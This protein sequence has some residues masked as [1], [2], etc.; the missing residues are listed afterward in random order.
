MK[1]LQVGAE[2][3][4]LVKTGGLADVLGALPQALVAAGADVRLLLP[5]FPAILAGLKKPTLVYEVGAAFGAA[6]VRLLRGTIAASG[7]SAYVVDAPYFYQRAGNPYLGADGM[8][9]PD[10]AQRFALLGWMAAQVAA[11]GLDPSWAPDV[12]HAHDWHA[13][14]AC[15]YVAANPGA[16]VATVYTVHNLAYQGLFD[17][18][19]F[20][21]LGLPV[22]FMEPTRLEYHGKFSFMKAGLTN[23]QRVTTVSPSYAAEIASSEFGCGLDGVVRSRG[24]DVSGILNGVDDAVWNPG[25]DKDIVSPYSATALEGKAVSKA[26][27]QK[28]L[29][30]RVDPKVPLFTVVSRLTEQ[31]GLDLVL[32]AIPEMLAAGA[33]LAVQGSGDAAL[34]KAFTDAMAAHPGVVAVRLGYD[35]PFAHQMIAGADA[36]LVPSRFEPCGLTQLY[37]L[38]YGTVPVVRRV[39]GLIDTVVD[40]DDATLLADTATG[41]M[42]GPATREALALAVHRTVHAYAQP[43]VWAQLQQRGMAQNFSWAAAATAYMALYEALCAPDTAR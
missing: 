8:E 38:R 9:W 16:R 30:L 14:M 33:Q 15:A 27:L 10:N 22:R 25:T 32:A 31:K 17:A 26:A 29:G 28:A 43:A 34:E 24:A 3:F 19:D 36:M 42:F 11:G 21:L 23:A 12:L 13:A 1:V 2:V 6:R 20:H 18:K 37:A 39:G 4:P 5:G 41:F 40:A 7:V 35:E